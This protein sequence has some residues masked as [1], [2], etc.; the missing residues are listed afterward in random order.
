MVYVDPLMDWGGS[1]KFKWPRSCHMFADNVDELHQLAHKIGLKRE[2]FQDDHVQHYDLTPNKRKAA[3]EQG[4]KEVD[5]RF[6][7]Q[8]MSNR[9][10]CKGNF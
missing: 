4:A 10:R 3:V 2:W 7:V 5:L 8:F 6:L 1:R 9:K